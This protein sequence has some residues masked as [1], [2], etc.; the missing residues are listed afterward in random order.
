MTDFIVKNMDHI[1]SADLVDMAIVS[2]LVYLVLIWF[3]QTRAAFI[4]VGILIFGAVYLLAR[5]YELYMTILIFRGFF[6]VLLVALVIIFQEELRHF[7]ERIAIWGFT[8]RKVPSS[9]FPLIEILMRTLSE[10]SVKRVGT[11]VVLQ[12]RD[13][14][15]R[16]LKGGFD[17][18]G[19]VSE[20][21][22]HS[23][24]DPHSM[25]HDGAVIIHN[26]R[27]EKFACYL[28]LSQNF[29]KTRLSG[30]RHAAAL[31][32]TERTD[33]LCLVVSEE[34]GRI[35]VAEEGKLRVMEG[36]GRLAPVLEGFFRERYPSGRTQ[37]WNILVAR[38]LREKAA[39]VAI[40]FVL[41]L[42][43]G[44]RTELVVREFQ[45][46]IAYK[47]LDTNLFIVDP[48]PQTAVVTFSGYERSFALFDPKELLIALDLAN[49][50]E[51]TQT[52]PVLDENVTYPDSFKVDDINPPVIKLKI[53]RLKPIS[54]RVEPEVRGTLPPGFKV[55]TV[56]VNP[57]KV[58]IFSPSNEDVSDLV[59]RTEAIDIEGLTQSQTFKTR[60]VVPP[61]MKHINGKFPDIE[62][63]VT[64]LPTATE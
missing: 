53:D 48:K 40:A 10:C 38:N 60:L 62:A 42:A 14:L 34:S 35:S 43:F 11:L 57:P 8:Y 1:T 18:D 64:I 15:D 37:L 25:G 44:P 20:A 56:R 36:V 29:A 7:F 55:D 17:L 61:G 22:L 13:P 21:L 2:T 50:S 41:W 59:F 54:V 33:A 58:D 9:A 4:L 19:Q 3:K 46:P 16:H 63:T 26:N 52:I 23:I 39:A 6:A 28:P 31:G 24:F 27:V 12:G 5:R 32:L 51:G 47:N 45:T 49:V 30:T